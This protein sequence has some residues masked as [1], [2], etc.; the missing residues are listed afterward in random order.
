MNEI[1]GFR[2]RARFTLFAPADFAAAGEDG[3]DGLLLS[4]MMD[5]GPRSRQ[6][7][8]QAA[9]DCRGDAE[10]RRDGGAAFRARRLRRSRIEFSWPDDV[11]R[12]G[13]THGV[14]VNF[15]SIE[16]KVSRG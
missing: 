12:S 2:T 15:E 7:L 10:R 1:P 6:Y 14:P 8:E 5:S 16:L 3:G 9:P 13:R 11:D 4:V